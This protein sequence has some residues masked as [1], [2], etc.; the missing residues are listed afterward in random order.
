VHAFHYLWYTAPDTWRGNT[1]LGYEIM[2]C[3]LDLQLYQELVYNFKPQFIVQTGVAGGGSI[4]YFAT[5]LDLAKAPP[6]AIVTGVDIILTPEARKLAHPRIRLFESDSVAPAVLK[7]IKQ[8]LPEGRGL[9]ILDSDHSKKH[10]LAELQ[11]YK[12]LVPVGSYLVVEDTNINGHPVF[13]SF[14]PGP[15]EAVQEFLKDNK[16]F[17]KEDT[18]WKRNKLSFH[19]WL[20][21]VS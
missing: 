16:N 1:F 6:E 4:L 7:E 19:Q 10:V 12:D 20:K 5:M 14:G 15:F 9:V 17:V 3:P 13:P 11:V 8:L 21:R 18:I 2:Q